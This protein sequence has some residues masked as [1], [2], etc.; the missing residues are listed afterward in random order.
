LTTAIYPQHFL[1][2]IHASEGDVLILTKPLG[3]ETV[4]SAYELRFSTLKESIPGISDEDLINAYQMALYSMTRMDAQVAKLMRKYNAHGGTSIGR[5][6]L[7]GHAQRLVT[8]QINP[9]D[10]VIYNLPI[11][12]NADKF[13]KLCPC[14]DSKVLKGLDQEVSGGLLVILPAEKAFHFM[15]DLEQVQKTPS[16]IVG[17]VKK[18][19]RTAKLSLYPRVISVNFPKISKH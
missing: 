6:G 15:K 7:L 2:P 18:G 8:S 3:I 14:P 19:S 11:F 13:S 1:P 5:Y 9:V 10:F 17:V 4:L 16:W 12:A